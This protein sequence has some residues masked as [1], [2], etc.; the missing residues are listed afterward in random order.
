MNKKKK[1]L[2]HGNYDDTVVPAFAQFEHEHSK[3]WSAEIAKHDGYVLVI[4]EYNYGSKFGSPIAYIHIS[5]HP[6]THTRPFLPP[7]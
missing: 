5:T 2:T 1:R 7:G 3:A 6:H 4:P